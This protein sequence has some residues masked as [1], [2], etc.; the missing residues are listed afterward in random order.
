MELQNKPC[1]LLNLPN[2]ILNEIFTN[3]TLLNLEGT[4]SIINLTMTT[5]KLEIINKTIN[6]IEN[7][8]LG[9]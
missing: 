2:D 8:N 7:E 1:Y 9:F 5:K 6:I 3:K 4:K